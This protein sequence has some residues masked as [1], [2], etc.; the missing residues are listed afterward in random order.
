MT[1]ISKMVANRNICVLSLSLSHHSVDM[2]AKEGDEGNMNSW[3]LVL[4]SPGE[5]SR[6]RSTPG[7]AGAGAG[8]FELRLRPAAPS[9]GLQTTSWVMSLQY[10]RCEPIIGDDNENL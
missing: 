6:S 5:D 10:E 3:R 4:I 9:T 8:F 2:G 1:Q 7:G